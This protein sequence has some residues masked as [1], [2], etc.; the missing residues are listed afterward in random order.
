MKPFVF[1][2]SLA[3]LVLVAPLAVAAEIES[4]A[5]PAGDP[6]TT[7]GSSLE[8]YPNFQTLSVYATYSGDSNAN[9]DTHMEYRRSGDEAWREGHHLTRIGADLWTGSIFWL[10]PGTAYEVRVTFTDPDAVTGDA[11]SGSVATRSDKWPTGSGKT[12]HVA[13][14]GK[15]DGSEAAPF[16]TIQHAVD[17]AAPGDTVLIAPGTYRESVTVTT[18]GTPE[19][20]ILIKGLPGATL[21]GSDAGF[22][23]RTGPDRWSGVREADRRNSTSSDFLADCDWDVNYVAI[24]DE[25][26]YGYDSLE[27]MKECRSGAPGGWWQ[28]KENHKLYVHNTRSYVTPNTTKTVVSRLDC[29]LALGSARYVV[30]DGLAV[31]YFG[32]MGISIKGSDNVVQNCLVH[33]Q[34]VGISIY[35]KAYNN[36]TIQDCHVFQTN[37]YR[38]P[39]YM[40]KNTRYEVDN[41]SARGGRGTVVRRNVIHGS[42][43]GIGLSVWEALNEPGW[44]QDTD[45]NDNEIY[46]CGDDGCEPEGTCTNLRF[47]NNR[48]RNALMGMSVA[49]IT[50]GPAYYVNETYW[51]SQLG[52]LK[53]KS[54]TKG[55]TFFYNCT[56]AVSGWRQAILQYR[57]RWQNIAFRNCAFAATSWVFAD[58]GP[59]GRNNSLDYDDLY[60]T[61][62]S[63]FMLWENTRYDSLAD[64]QKAG[65]EQHGISADPRFVDATKGDFTLQ[66]ESPLIDRGLH[67]PGINDDFAGK[68]PDIGSHE[69]RQQ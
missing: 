28:D 41:I 3:F 61:D 54:R 12:L 51:D 56:I 44:M 32:K 24:N 27:K 42:F 48:I 55:P 37:V 65:V 14:G 5:P 43:D 58:E 52:A 33:H 9:N 16:G 34:D 29:G 19:A 1:V 66:A 39:W 62:P 38:W 35:G 22:L 2:T 15:G 31:Q 57:D 50:V 68:A 23:D 64:L 7:V 69:L 8:L 59:E 18:S 17:A 21:D 60:T 11:L 10:T 4:T 63:R 26:F 6:V 13:P 45:I 25:E 30:V 53:L 46:D 67:I 20:Y 36:N 49:P 40:T 47:F